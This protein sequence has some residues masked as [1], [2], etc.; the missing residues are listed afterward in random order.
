MIA[1]FGDV[2]DVADG[3]AQA[4]YQI[5]DRLAGEHF[6]QPRA[7]DVEYLAA[8]RQYRLDAAIPALLGRAACRVSLYDKQFRLRR[9]FALAVG[10][11]AWQ[12]ETLHRALAQNRVFG[13]L[14][15]LARLKRQHRF[16]DDGPRVLGLLLQKHG[17]RLAKDGVYSSTRLNGAELGFSLAL[18]LD[19]GKFDRNYRRQTFEHVLAGKVLLAFTQCI[20][21]ARVGVERTRERTL[22]AGH[23]SAALC[24]INVV[25]KG[26]HPRG[27]VVDILQR[28][29]HNNAVLLLFHIKYIFVDRLV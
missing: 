14:G 28:Y 7:L 13:R 6:V 3:G 20:A 29:L 22:K 24:G 26:E 17:K 5:F 15:G 16:A 2:E 10:K 8:Q 25:G 1:Q 9:L 19:F 18:K 21:F 27:Q 12:T 23:M 4:Q 11:F